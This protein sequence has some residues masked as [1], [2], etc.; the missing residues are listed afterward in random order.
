M[1]SITYRGIIF[2]QPD[3]DDVYNNRNRTN[4]AVLCGRLKHQPCEIC[5]HEISIAHHEIYS[6]F[7]NVRWLCYSDHKVIHNL[8]DKIRS[9]EAAERYLTLYPKS[10]IVHIWI[11]DYKK[12]LSE[13]N[14]N[15]EKQ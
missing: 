15:K 1:K 6:D 13:L 9:L 7:M 2:Y 4:K 10:D 8:L 5:G 3:Y 11:D 14:F 12:E